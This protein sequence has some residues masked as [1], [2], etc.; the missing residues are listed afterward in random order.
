MFVI[1]NNCCGGHCYRMNASQFNTP[2]TWCIIPYDSISK[3]LTHFY[4]IDFSKFTL[5]QSEY[6][7]N[8]FV[9]TVDKCVQLHYVHYLFDASYSSIKRITNGSTAEFNHS[10][11]VKWNHIW[12]YVV[13]KYIERT[14]RMVL[15]NEPPCFVIQE[16]HYIGNRNQRFNCQSL[17][18]INSPFKRYIITTSPCVNRVDDLVKC[19]VVKNLECPLPTINKYF[20]D[21]KTFFNIK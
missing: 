2:F 3:L 9:I 8:S 16:N 13:E 18:K 15:L 17:M 12:E 21:I 6:I 14:K 20:S 7:H 11:E 5:A 19:I 4:D 10:S 1:S